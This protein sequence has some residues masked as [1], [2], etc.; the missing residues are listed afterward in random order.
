LVCGGE[1][2]GVFWCASTFLFCCA[3]FFFFFFFFFLFSFFFFLFFLKTHNIIC[4]SFSSLRC[5]DDRGECTVFIHR[6]KPTD[7]Q[8]VR[9]EREREEREMRRK[10]EE[11]EAEQRRLEQAEIDGDDEV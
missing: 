9:L 4:C 5:V 3:T 1:G 10:E 2:V 7:W 8:E 6:K 11:I